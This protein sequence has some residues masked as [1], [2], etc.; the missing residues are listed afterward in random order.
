MGATRV[1]L[2]NIMS[3]FFKHGRYE[4]DDKSIK[5]HEFDV[6]YEK[7]T[8][9]ITYTDKKKNQTYNGPVLIDNLPKYVSMNMLAESYF[10]FKKL[11][12]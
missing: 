11:I 6:N 12:K 5:I 4:D 3:K 9:G 2:N 8:V 7:Q 1:K 10:K